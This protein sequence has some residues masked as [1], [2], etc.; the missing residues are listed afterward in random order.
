MDGIPERKSTALVVIDVQDRFMPVIFEMGR[1]AEN[2]SK[3]VKA[4]KIL[5]VPVVFTEQ[6]PQGLGQTIPD[7][8]VLME[9]KPLEK[10]EFSCFK[11]KAFKERL[12]K[13]RK[14]GVKQLVLC[15][16]EAHVC[17]LQTALDAIDKGYEVYVV[18]DAVS[19]RK[20]TDWQ[21]AM[22]RLQQSGAYRVSTEMIIFQL[23]EKAG[24]EEFKKVQE[25]IK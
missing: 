1:V 21:T 24:T 3:L 4:L 25:I 22:D 11:N 23:M 6:Y 17:V 5:K 7:L 19:S 10:I 18:E 9:D 2:C 14:S 20:R 8:A 16:I 13:L 12:Y 15:G